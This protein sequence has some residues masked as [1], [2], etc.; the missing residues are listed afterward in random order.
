MGDFVDWKVLAVNLL[1]MVPMFGLGYAAAAFHP[2][3]T[4][5]AIVWFFAADMMNEWLY[6]WFEGGDYHA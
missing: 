6:E 1:I 2:A 3:W 4:V 5:G